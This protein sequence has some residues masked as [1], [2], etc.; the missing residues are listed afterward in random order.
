MIGSSAEV[1][2]K[3]SQQNKQ[4]QITALTVVEVVGKQEPYT[5]FRREMDPDPLG[6]A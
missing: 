4:I 2:S 6:L 3:K 1:D 5:S